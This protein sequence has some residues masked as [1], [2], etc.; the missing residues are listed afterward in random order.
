MVAHDTAHSSTEAPDQAHLEQFRSYLLC[1]ALL[2]L[3]DEPVAE[4]VVQGTL[5]AALDR[6]RLAP[7]ECLDI[8]WRK[9]L[10]RARR[11][12]ARFPSCREASMLLSLAQ[13]RPLDRWGRYRLHLHVCEGCRHFATHMS[14]VRA[15]IKRYVEHDD[16]RR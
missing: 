8:K 10:R 4:D 15:A 9:I 13:D 1:S 11:A 16:T 12:R 6:A 14:F 2:Q 5:P 3:R 7:R